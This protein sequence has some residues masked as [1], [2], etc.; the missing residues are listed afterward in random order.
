MKNVVKLMFSFLVLISF[1]ANGQNAPAF[2]E[3]TLPNEYNIIGADYPRVGEDGRTYFK[4]FAPDAQKVE[5]S[6]RG[7]MEKGD[8]GFWTLISDEPEVIGFHYYQIIIDDVSVADPHGKPFFGMGKWVSGIEIPEKGGDYYKPKQGVPHGLVSESWYYSEVRQE[9]RRCFVYT[10][11]G[12]DKESDKSYPVLYLQHGMGE[13]ET[14]WSNQGKMN[15]IMDNLIAEGKVTPMIVVMD[16]GNIEVLRAAPGEDMNEVRRKFGADFSAILLEEIIP[17]IE[18]NFRVLTDRENRAMAGLSWGGLQTFNITLNNLDKFS[19]IGGFSGA[20]RIDLN[21]LDAA[22]N[23]VFSDSAA[24]NEKVKVFF[25]GVGSEENPERT[26]SLSD[27]LKKAG[28]D[29]IYYES[30]GTAH[31]FLT[32]RRCLKEFAPLLFK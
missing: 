29:N 10:P 8:D 4:V 13:N 16:N 12:Y 3:G 26:K 6:F 18:A 20:G 32:W 28:I 2:P 11:P 27:G 21:N 30:P 7:E 9:W 25:L 1:M 5:I 23:G 17:H 15:F 31:E 24:F 14:S 19:Y 22:Y